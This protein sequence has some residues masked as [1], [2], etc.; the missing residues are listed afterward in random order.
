MTDQSVPTPDARAAS[1]ARLPT[2]T[3]LLSTLAELGRE[4]T[5][6]L[7]IEELLAKIPVLIARLTRFS[8]FSVYLLDEKAQ[9]LNDAGQPIAGLLA[10]GATT[11]GLEGGS[12]AGYSG[13]LSK[14]S[15][16][17]IIAAE[18]LAAS[19]ALQD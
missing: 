18:T 3:E 12:H 2:D 13:G 9:V 1:A 5:S 14:A 17:G 16:F 4:V 6:V 11:G 10:A 7:A 15:V 19:L 8:A